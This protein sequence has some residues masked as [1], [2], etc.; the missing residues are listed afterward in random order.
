MKLLIA[1]DSFKGTM[2]SREV[3]QVIEEQ[4]HKHIKDLEVIQVPI[5]DGGEGTVDALVSVLQGD[6]IKVRVRGPLGQP[7]DATYGLKDQVAI[8]EMAAASGIIHLQNN[9][10][11]P[12][13]TTTF[14][15]GEMILDALVRGVKKIVIGIGGSATNDGGMGMAMALGIRFM[16][17]HGHDIVDGSGGNLVRVKR[18]DMTG[19]DKRLHD[20]EIEVICDVTNPLTGPLGATQVY[21]PQKGA[22]GIVLEKLESGMESYACL[23]TDLLGQDINEIPGAGAAGG[24]GAALVTFLDGRL[25]PG[26]EAVL[27]LI[28][29][30]EQLQ[31]VDMVITGEGRLDGQSVFG[32][33]P[34]GVS[35][36]CLRKNIP[37]T[38][39][40][41]CTGEGY[42]AV[43]AYGIKEVIPTSNGRET[44]EMITKN[45]KINLAKA[46][47]K[48][49]QSL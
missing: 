23:L 3:I 34:V 5:A 14:G 13:K 33:V 47:D 35:K 49:F 36:R 24:L 45:A 27:D 25:R 10:L 7:I 12:L 32:K 41:G 21:G 31:G 46:A 37:V 8:M 29:F 39:I 15:T 11:N 43:Y 20:V 48:F 30:D 19:L 16:D 1:P 38:A 42:E 26:I 17:E 44:E 6:L 9:M 2:T 4:G 28:K 22:S 18:I 40:V